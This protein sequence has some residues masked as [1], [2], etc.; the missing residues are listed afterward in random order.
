MFIKAS[1]RQQ[2]VVTLARRRSMIFT[3][4]HYIATRP[5]FA[6]IFLALLVAVS[7]ESKGLSVT[8]NLCANDTSVQQM[9]LGKIRLPESVNSFGS[10]LQPVMDNDGIT[11][12]FSRKHY[13]ENTGGPKD[14]DD[15]WRSTKLP[16][17]EGWN[18]ATNVGKPLNTKGSDVILSIVNSGK[19]AFI[20]S[21]SG[22]ASLSTH[23]FELSERNG[24]SWN[25]PIPITIENYQSR[26]TYF[27]ASM[28]EDMSVILLAIK[29]EDSNGS[30][31]I[32]VSFRKGNSFVWSEP[33]NLGRMINT[34]EIEG[35]PFLARDGKTLYF[36]SAGHGGFGKQD[37][38]VAKRLDDSWT[39][40]SKPQNLGAMVNTIWDDHC[41]TLSPDDKTAY[42]ISSDSVNHISGI[43]EFILP[44]QMRPEKSKQSLNSQATQSKQT[45]SLFS[46][47][48]PTGVSTPSDSVSL[49]FSRIKSTQRPIR[50]VEI[51]G[52]ADTS[53]GAGYNV[54]LSKQRAEKIAEY[55]RKEKL[56]D[57]IRIMSVGKGEEQTVN[58]NTEYSL[59]KSRRVDVL[60]TFE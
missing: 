59:G 31:D 26:S 11:L 48:Y 9:I 17:G 30:L 38:F 46:I 41:Y 1:I 33:K 52:F 40:W 2:S 49:L 10:E 39:S 13:P 55:V 16:N 34:G 56:C 37:M 3:S 43:Y 42:I 51:I 35:S 32:Y 57:S 47:Y 22:E 20:E 21:T 60:I 18:T 15:I 27:Y 4:F 5:T 19:T 58:D 8:N 25:K 29:G 14:P 50:K 54:E 44:E 28:S 6:P 24:N 36:S 12:Y 23:Y 45:T 53:G 7:A